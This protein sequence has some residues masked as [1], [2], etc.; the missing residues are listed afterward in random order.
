MILLNKILLNRL[1]K[2]PL[3]FKEQGDIINKIWLVHKCKLWII[4]IKVELEKI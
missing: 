1:L 4:I 3:E 2:L